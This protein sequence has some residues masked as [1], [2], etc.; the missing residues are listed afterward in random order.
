MPELP[1][2]KLLS[3]L[4]ICLWS[5]EREPSGQWAY[6]YLAPGLE[7]I[8]GRSAEFFR[9]GLLRWGS[10]VHPVD[11]PAWDQALVRLRQ[12]QRGQLD[13]RLLWPD[14]SVRWV[15]ESLHVVGEAEGQ[16]VCFAGV[17]TDITDR[18]HTEAEL[19]LLLQLTRAIAEAA[20]VTAALQVALRQVCETTGWVLGEAWVPSP[21]GRALQLS[22]AWYST[23]EYWVRYRAAS[24]AFRFEFGQGLPGKVWQMRRPLWIKDVTR[25]PAFLRL[26]LAADVGLKSA[27]AVPVMEGEEVQA[28]MGFFTPE[29]RQEDEHLLQLV[30]AVAAQ[31]G[32]VLKRKQTEE[33]LDQERHC[34]H[35]LM[36]IV[37]DHIYFKDTGGRFLRANR[38][39]ACRFGLADPQQLVGK[40]DFDFFVPHAA[41]AFFSDEQQVIQAGQPLIAKEEEELWPDG[42]ATWASTTTMPLADPQGRIIGVLGISRDV[43]A[44]K[45]A[46]EELRLSKQLLE[47]M[48]QENARLLAHVQEAEQKYRSIF[49]NASEG[50][51]Q[52]TPD[53]HYLTANPALA[54]IHGYSTPQELIAAVTEIGRQLYVHPARR[55]E[56]IRLIEAH[57]AVHDFQYQTQRKDGS[58]I[59]ISEN[60]RA[61]RDPTGVVL[62]YEG[63]A[64]DITERKR[65]EEALR[66]S[67]ARYQSLVENLAQSVLLKDSEFRFC[68][69]NTPFCQMVGRSASDILGRTDFD[70]FPPDL[71]EKYRRDDRHILKSGARLEMDEECLIGGQRRTVRT[72]K[73]PVKDAQDQIV[74]V[75]G[76]FWDV[77]EQRVLEA[78]LRQAQKMEA[79]GQLAG[80]VAH[81]FNNLLTAIL[82]NLALVLGE[83][84][85]GEAHRGLLLETERAAA[86][87]AELTRQLLGFARQ[88]V[89]RLEPTDLGG[90]LQEV[91]GL[92]R[93]TIDPR[94][95]VEVQSA[96]DLWTVQADPS[97]IHQVLMNLCLNARDAMPQG[98]R[99]SLEAANVAVDPDYARLH[100][101][102]W[103]GAFIRVRVRDS[104]CGI[105]PEI[106]ARIF[107]PFFTTKGPGKGTG[108]GLALVYGIVKQHQGW[109]ECYSEVDQGT[110]FH[111]YLPRC[112]GTTETTNHVPCQP[113]QAPRGGNETILLVDDDEL[114]RALGRTVLQRY[115]YQVLLAEDGL[116]ALEIYRREQQHI[117][118]II[119]D[120]H[121]PQMSGADA[122]EELR[123]LSPAVR[124]LVSSGN[125]AEYMSDLARAD[126]LGFIEK[127]YRPQELAASV[128]TALDSSGDSA[129]AAR[130]G[131]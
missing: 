12:G 123:R 9:A 66:A 129:G 76:S 116:Q 115:G 65:A 103:A 63:T 64:E 13:Y 24:A 86:R 102:A 41:E 72:V 10:V 6:R 124:V 7:K 36:D 51:F 75:V 87:A 46:E 16:P 29:T 48:V 23:T 81:D 94:I 120:L 55:A 93:R 26:H 121:M 2:E 37:P 90:C 49:E 68:A 59:W 109:I 78:Q 73:T 106:R 117:A 30:S 15:Q 98:G 4:D 79:V 89:L 62:Y 96:A 112:S 38:A 34:L 5:A 25:D 3:T 118:L 52:T 131:R 130:V 20:D 113:G 97:Q 119:L 91:T 47:Q 39:V 8:M 58:T 45:Q 107:E 126:T 99:L 67:E 28:V 54:R 32:S 31:V 18:R 43:T 33:A 11:R 85:S 71:A 82:G 80:G 44:R 57:G 95:T 22:P 50:I 84:P 77:T 108:L 114:I 111:I 1:L 56:F 125:P 21:D 27:L 42:K 88:T 104:G 60:A 14:G 35:A 40:T 70:L 19:R 17:V 53:G 127:P 128:R 83:L 69:V 100:A 110:T 61:V 92:L 101:D 105:A 74:G 122:L